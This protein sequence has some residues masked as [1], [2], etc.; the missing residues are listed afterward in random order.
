[1]VVAALASVVL[2]ACATPAAAP[3]ALAPLPHPIRFLLT[4]DDGPSGMG[5]ANPTESILADLKDNPIQP[6]IKALFFVQTRGATVY[7]LGQHLLAR[8]N[9]EGHLIGLHTATAGHRNHRFLP[10]A[11]FTASLDRGVEDIRRATAQRTTLVRPPFWSYNER[12]Y[13]TYRAHGLDMLLTDLSA[14]DG[15][16]WGFTASLHKRSNLC[17][18]LAA[19]RA[20]ILEGGL[21]VV[22]GVI[23]VV[24]TFHD[25]NS[26]TARHLVEY[27][28]ILL[29]VAQA[30]NMPTA[31][32]P[33]YDDRATLARAAHARAVRDASQAVAL[34]GFWG[35]IWTETRILFK[36]TT[37]QN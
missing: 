34:P 7:A 26:Y 20:A 2:A 16:I 21:P 11:E 5:Y 15:V 30:L 19:T 36:S 6:H 37:A 9:G 28:H 22:D 14:N 4:F 24:V 18:E 8:E 17:N 25:T 23:P 3:V 31:A 1:M 12:T 10:A 32:E 29:D 27:M 13:A 33:F 35:W